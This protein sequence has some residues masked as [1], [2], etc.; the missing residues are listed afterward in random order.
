MF[1]LFVIGF[2]FVSTLLN[3]LANSVW[4]IW[5]L[6]VVLGLNIQL[7]WHF[8]NNSVTFFLHVC[9]VFKFD[10]EKFLLKKINKWKFWLKRV[11]NRLKHR[12]SSRAWLT[13]TFISDFFFPTIRDRDLNKNM[14]AR[15]KTLL[16]SL[17]IVTD[18]REWFNRVKT[19]QL[20]VCKPSI[21]SRYQQYPSEWNNNGLVW[22][23]WPDEEFQIPA[24][25]APSKKKLLDEFRKYPPWPVAWASEF[26]SVV[27]WSL[28]TVESS[29]NNVT[30]WC[31]Q[32]WQFCV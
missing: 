21:I 27:I 2:F 1:P 14:A 3:M 10:I 29:Q 18:G 26:F 32:H 7:L 19:S 24:K 8:F 6:L 15:C 4:S 23:I 5:L 12:A 28:K 30:V 17:E 11:N 16:A 22:F 13:S 31:V 25:H 20:S 9:F